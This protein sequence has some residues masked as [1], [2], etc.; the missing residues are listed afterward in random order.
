MKI[1]FEVYT[2]DDSPGNT[3]LILFAQTDLQGN[4]EICNDG[5]VFFNN[6]E[7]LV[8]LEDFANIKQKPHSTNTR[9]YFVCRPIGTHLWTVV[10]GNMVEYDS[11]MSLADAIEH[12]HSAIGSR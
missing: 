1:A 6:E 3:P 2:R 4:W 9:D 11:T 5:S 12:M 10:D 7:S 8:D